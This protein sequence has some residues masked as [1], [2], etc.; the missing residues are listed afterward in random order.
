MSVKQPR[1]AKLR[2]AWCEACQ[3]HIETFP[4]D[5]LLSSGCGCIVVGYLQDEL[6]HFSVDQTVDRLPVDVCDEVTRTQSSFLC[7]T[8]VLHMLTVSQKTS[9][10]GTK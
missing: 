7:R 4:L 2:G 3:K 6:H 10:I 9:Q 1:D 8:I 5:K